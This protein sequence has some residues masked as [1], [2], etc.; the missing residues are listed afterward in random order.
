MMNNA[1]TD[2]LR[3]VAIGV[4]IGLLGACKGSAPTQKAEMKTYI[5]EKKT[6]HKTLFF[7]GTIK[8]LKESA[9]TSPAESIV[10]TMHFH[11]G[12]YVKSNQ[13]VFTLNSAE[14]QKQYN[15]TLTEYLKAKDGYSI[16]RSKFT[17]TEELWQS[18]LLSKN[19]YLNEKS[20]LNTARVTL[21]QATRKLSEML[22]KMGDDT[23]KD[24]SS[25]SF[26]EFDKVRSALAG[27]HHLIHIRAP[28]DGVLLYPPKASDDKAQRITVGAQIKA[29]QVLAL[30]GDMS[31]IRVE[32]DI[33]EVDIN[34][35]K[36]GLNATIHG[37][38]FGKEELHG[39]LISLN[40]EATAG[41]VG[42]LPSFTALVEVK[43]LTPE[44]QAWVKVGMSAAIEVAVDNMEKM[45]VP[46]RAVTQ[47]NGKSVVHKRLKD[48]TVQSVSVVTGA[49][50]GE[51]VVIDRGLQP[52]DVIAYE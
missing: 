12:Q 46:V 49:V 4:L 24:L 51:D 41:S 15:D 28:G 16:A 36:P 42:S 50:E 2:Y 17:G 27:K 26:S 3:L 1:V 44:E 47:K 7:T 20:S 30:I 31:G 32:I 18:G 33:P 39:K 11:Y 34:K 25:L 23:Y 5:V 22:E 9:L 45:L 8:P 38:A 29:G 37:V 48:G 14:L 43:N 52:G 40:A 6:L 19:N 13:E 35:V 21:L 10:E